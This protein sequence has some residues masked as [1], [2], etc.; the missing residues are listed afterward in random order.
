[1]VPWQDCYLRFDNPELVLEQ[2]L[3]LLHESLKTL[4]PCRKAKISTHDQPWITP[5]IKHCQC[6]RRRFFRRAKSRND[7]ASW[8]AYKSADKEYSDVTSTAKRDY[9][10]NLCDS[11]NATNVCAKQWWKLLKSIYGGKNSDSNN[12]IPDLIIDG[13]VVDDIF[14]KC[15]ILNSFFV[16]QSSLDDS[17]VPLPFLQETGPKCDIPTFRSDL[18][19]KILNNFK[20]TS[21]ATGPDGLLNLLVL[22]RNIAPGI[23]EPITNFFN[24]S[25]RS[26]TFHTSWK[27]ANVTQ[28]HK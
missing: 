21:K 13:Q 4:I 16:E 5:Y 27:V 7:V 15:E 23:V 11:L 26:G 9:S 14:Q 17:N 8:E 25:I 10:K 19:R 12:V 18:V 20:K 2:W 24:Y 1:M 28:L 22:L 6:V 3:K